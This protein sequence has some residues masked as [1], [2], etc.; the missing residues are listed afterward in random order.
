VLSVLE[1]L[2]GLEKIVLVIDKL[3]GSFEVDSNVS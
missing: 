2:S 3:S 1:D